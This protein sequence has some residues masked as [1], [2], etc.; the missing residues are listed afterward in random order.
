MSASLLDL[1]CQMDIEG[2]TPWH[3]NPTARRK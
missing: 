1:I 2:F 3:R